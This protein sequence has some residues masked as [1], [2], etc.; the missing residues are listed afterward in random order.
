[1]HVTDGWGKFQATRFYYDSSRAYLAASSHSVL[2][3]LRFPSVFVAVLKRLELP[4]TLQD[5]QAVLLCRMPQCAKA[6]K[7]LEQQRN[8][9]VP[10][11]KKRR[12]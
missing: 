8:R 6:E 12:P 5:R 9:K 2:A 7:K 4:F 3:K 11:L 10:R 1:M